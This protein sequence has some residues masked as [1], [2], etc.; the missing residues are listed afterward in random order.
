MH[1]TNQEALLKEAY[2]SISI[3]IIAF[4]GEDVITE[5][6]CEDDGINGNKDCFAYNA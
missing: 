4:T 6:K 3:E 1:R 2:E 5:S